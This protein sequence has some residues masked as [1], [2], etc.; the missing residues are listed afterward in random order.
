MSTTDT[1]ER[2]VRDQ[3]AARGV[4][5]TRVL[6]AMREVPRDAFVSADVVEFAYEDAPLPIEEGQTISQPYIVAVMAEALELE[7]T[8]RVLDV[9]TGSGYAAAVLAHVAAEVYTVERHRSLAEAARERFERLG[10]DNVHVRVGDGTL[11]WEEEAPFDAI[12][13]AAGGP[14]VPR[15]LKEQLAPGGVMVI[16]TGDRERAQELTRVRRTSDGFERTSLGGVRFV[17][18]VGDQGWAPK[19]GAD[20]AK[21][22][23]EPTTVAE[24]IAR[25]AE[26]FGEID[27]ADLDA[28]LERVGDARVVLLGEATHGTSEFYRMRTR[29]TRELVERKGFDMVAVEADWPDAAVVDRH[30]RHQD[31]G[32]PPAHPP[33]RRFPRWMWRN[34]EVRELVAW[35]R[36]HNEGLDDEERVGFHGLDLYSLHASMDAVLAYLDEHDPEAAEAAR[37][38]YGCLTPWQSDPA[39][40]GRAVL[41]G[42]YRECEDDV[43][44]VLE[45]I[46]SDRID[47]LS[48]RGARR[49]FDAEQNARLVANAERYYRI[50][51][52]GGRA[53]WNL[54]DQH[55]FDTLLALMRFYGPESKA[56]V[57]E[58]NS[59]IGDASATAM[60]ARG[61]HNVGQLSRQHFGPGAYLVGF[62]THTGTVAA[63]HDWGDP[64]EVMR[65][66]PS[67]EDSYER[68]CHDSGVERFLLPLRRRGGEPGGHPPTDGATRSSLARKLLEERLERA[69]GVVYRPETELQSHYFPACLPRQFDEYV[70]FDETEAVTP[71]EGAGPVDDAGVETAETFPF[72][73]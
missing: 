12:N 3:I 42:R 1:R 68:L 26:P 18:L 50:M 30:V 45:E 27:D 35:L 49:Y 39:T 63:A 44:E 25:A 29:I 71:L 17:P 2:M 31:D 21:G 24:H 5:D 54:R 6:D 51:Y 16:P 52:Y 7:P 32:D 47:G 69:I 34:E 48:A 13:V 67:R 53:S 57:W 11:G 70:W 14:D 60:G 46:L 10:I 58:H 38:R 15:S 43:V 33:F 65:V 36:D 9:G 40:Y 22:A 8:D 19:E 23:D 37:T 64:M 56:V 55:M 73:V 59:H 62:G 41:S 4:R 72:G 20:A 28:F 61:Q 66:R